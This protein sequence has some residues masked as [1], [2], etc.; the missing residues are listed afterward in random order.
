MRANRALSAAENAGASRTKDDDEDEDESKLRNLGSI[1][2]FA[3]EI[4][5]DF[6]ADTKGGFQARHITG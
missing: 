1:G 5:H 3:D 2:P 6:V 4:G